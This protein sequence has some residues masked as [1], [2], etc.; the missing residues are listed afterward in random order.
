MSSADA[1]RRY[2]DALRAH[3]LDALVTCWAPGGIERQVGQRELTAPEG[4]RE[5]FRE[6]HGAFPDLAWEVLDV[7][8][9]AGHRVAVRWRATGTF[10]GPGTFQGFV[11]NGA[12]VEMEGCDVVSV[13]AEGRIAR[14]DAY[15]DSGAVARQLGLLPPAGSRAE[16]SL[17]KLAN[18]RTRA[19]AWVHGAE[20][21]RIADGVWIVRGGIGRHMNVYLIEDEGAVTLFDAGISEMTEVVAAAAARLGAIRRI[22]LGHADC[23]HRGTA[24]G[25]RAPVYC[26]PA[27]RAA[28]EAASPYRDYWDRAKLD[29]RGR[30]VL[31]R[32]NAR[33]DGGAVEIA[34][35]VNEGDEIAGFKVVHLPGH[36]PGLIG[37]FRESDRL[38]LVSDAIY[39][40]DPQSGRKRPASVPHPAFNQ[41]TTQARASIRKLAALDPSSVW[42]GHTDPVTGD[43]QAQLEQAA[44]APV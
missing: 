23:D 17:T 12:R 41:D 40:V 25:L 22:V 24:P 3:D 33:W 30:T 28:A 29:P 20:P 27:D 1:V 15:L 37:L 19:Q 26:H 18:A 44:S 16:A 38:A 39:T 43:V 31:W 13:D 32:L 34:G 7:I 35:T 11:P 21:E 8:A 4:V 42:A 5:F 6:L 36:A 10:A 9:D 2:F 14:L